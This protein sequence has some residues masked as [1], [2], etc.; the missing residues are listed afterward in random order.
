MF[1]DVEQGQT[2]HKK[3]ID[4]EKCRQKK[5]KQT[6]RKNAFKEGKRRK[7]IKN[8]K[9]HFNDIP[10]LKGKNQINRAQ[11]SIK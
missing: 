4:R 2:G 11:K 5:G 3:V 10:T 9:K 1:E 7:K 6:T 8:T